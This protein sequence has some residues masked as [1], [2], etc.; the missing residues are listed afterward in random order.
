MKQHKIKDLTQ[1][2]QYQLTMVV[3][4]LLDRLE[5]QAMFE[6]IDSEDPEIVFTEIVLEPKSD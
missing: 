3:S 1:L 4:L 2:S 5:L 6:E